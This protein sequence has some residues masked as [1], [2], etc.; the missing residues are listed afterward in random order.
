MR[1]SMK[2]YF[3]LLLVLIATTIP[4][5]SAATAKRASSLTE[6][7]E[8]QSALTQQTQELKQALAAKT[9][10]IEQEKSSALNLPTDSKTLS[11]EQQEQLKHFFNTC[12]TVYGSQNAQQILRMIQNDPKKLRISLI[13]TQTHG[14]KLEAFIKN[15]SFLQ[16]FVQDPE[17]LVSQA[18]PYRK[19]LLPS[20]ISTMTALKT[21]M[22][23]TQW[24]NVMREF[25]G[26]LFVKFWSAIWHLVRDALVL[27]IGA[28]KIYEVD[29]YGAI[30]RD[31]QNQK[32][33]RLIP[34]YSVN[35]NGEAEKKM[36]PTKWYSILEDQQSIL[37]QIML[38]GIDQSTI[39]TLQSLDRLLL[40]PIASKTLNIPRWK[41][42][43]FHY[44][45]AMTEA[46]NPRSQLATPRKLAEYIEKSPNKFTIL[47]AGLPFNSRAILGTKD[48]E[49]RQKMLQV[50]IAKQ[51][52]HAYEPIWAELQ[53]SITVATRTADPTAT[54][55]LSQ[56]APRKSTGT[57][58]RAQEAKG[59]ADD[60]LSE[61]IEVGKDSLKG[62]L[63]DGPLGM[64]MLYVNLAL[65]IP[66]AILSFDNQEKPDTE[67][68]LK[69]ADGTDI[70]AGDILKAIEICEALARYERRTHTES[71][72]DYTK[73]RPYSITITHPGD[74]EPTTYQFK[75]API[76]LT[77]LLEA[78]E[79]GLKRYIPFMTDLGSE[80][81]EEYITKLLMPRLIFT[82]TPEAV[83]NKLGIRTIADAASSI[84]LFKRHY[85]ITFDACV[86]LSN[87]LAVIQKFDGQKTL[88][89]HYVEV[90]DIIDGF[91]ISIQRLIA[92]VHPS[93]RDNWEARIG[94]IFHLG[95]TDLGKKINELKKSIKWAYEIEDWSRLLAKKGPFSVTQ[96]Q[97]IN[98]AQQK[99]RYVNPILVTSYADALRF[100]NAP[101]TEL[102]ALRAELFDAKSSASTVQYALRLQKEHKTVSEYEGQ[103]PLSNL[104]L[105]QLVV[106][107]YHDK[108]NQSEIQS[109][110]RGTRGNAEPKSATEI[111]E[112]TARALE[113]ILHTFSLLTSNTQSTQNDFFTAATQKTV[114][115][116][117]SLQ[118]ELSQFKSTINSSF[119]QGIAHVQ[120]GLG[121]LHTLYSNYGLREVIAALDEHY[122]ATG[123]RL[124]DIPLPLLAKIATKESMAHLVGRGADYLLQKTILT[125]LMGKINQLQ[126]N[127]LLMAPAL[128]QMVKQQLST[129]IGGSGGRTNAYHAARSIIRNV[130]DYGTTALSGSSLGGTIAARFTPAALGGG[131]PGIAE[132]QELMLHAKMIAKSGR[133]PTPAIAARL[134]RAGIDPN[135][136]PQEELDE[137]DEEYEDD[138][139]STN[140]P[141][142]SPA[143]ETLFKKASMI[144]KEKG[145]PAAEKYIAE[146]FNKLSKEDQE[147]L[148]KYGY[149]E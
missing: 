126:E 26:S 2:K 144:A 117:A 135:N 137:E 147:T 52:W 32:L 9:A 143:L 97:K 61:A 114:K 96:K 123:K 95:D 63:Q 118:S 98:L 82:L 40:R 121:A 45:L 93:H 83:K 70:P 11:A 17:K 75:V 85:A 38:S 138:E 41:L 131:I 79:R 62:K 43:Y 106:T 127:G 100:L 88:A 149:G 29:K 58:T 54:N 119:L 86:M 49:T 65:N 72:S 139:E 130:F 42:S 14:H 122:Y 112:I 124:N 115:A 21:Y 87:M 28:E 129:F 109:T 53:S 141:A 16:L 59:F 30:K 23:P 24:G 64:Y 3:V 48:T 76:T 22:S 107:W 104:S 102:P 105:Q 92:S 55:N 71:W 25:I 116:D 18:R 44:R 60:V 78:Q 5:T 36:I 110:A 134:K 77:R 47:T 128:D 125:P 8:K 6:Y 1:A 108:S 111:K 136:L 19:P 132:H 84:T 101:A 57:K 39:S 67:L 31:A 99:S 51:L 73:V 120:K 91:L 13:L 74:T 103:A 66:H 46:K 10:A 27:A 15:P 94:Q 50:A 80:S 140:A 37:G 33:P 35:E 34:Q 12:S 146:E 81:Y 133:T 4:A 20:I 56:L 145:E 90:A 148:K 68:T 142:L 7:A 113:I 89:G 69:T